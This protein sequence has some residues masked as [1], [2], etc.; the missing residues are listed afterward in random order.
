MGNERVKF[1]VTTL[2]SCIK[3]NIKNRGL[4]FWRA[5]YT[6]RAKLSCSCDV[7]QSFI[8]PTSRPILFWQSYC[9]YPFTLKSRL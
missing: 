1:Y 5:Q 3:K 4:L 6:S 7:T 8:P 2:Y 9:V